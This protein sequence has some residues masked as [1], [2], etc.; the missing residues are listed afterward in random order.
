M[1]LGRGQHSQGIR[2]N[3]EASQRKWRVCLAYRDDNW[4]ERGNPGQ[5]KVDGPRVPFLGVQKP[6][7]KRPSFVS[8]GPPEKQDQW[9]A[10]IHRKRFIIRNWLMCPW[11]LTSPKICRQCRQAAE[12]G[13]PLVS[14]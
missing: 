11:R 6:Y 9:D 13:E 4:N 14:F 8:Q 5:I 7:I 12:P 2:G 1:L 10:C 3:Y